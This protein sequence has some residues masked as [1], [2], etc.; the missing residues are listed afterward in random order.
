MCPSS[1]ELTVSVRYLV[2]AT[3]C[4]QPSGMHT[5]RSSNAIPGICH[6]V[7]DLLVCV[8]DVR[9][10]RVTYTRYRIDTVNSLDGGHMVARNM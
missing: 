3:L 8:P 7:D 9:R 2:Y 6:C 4:G 1:G 10:H 5:R